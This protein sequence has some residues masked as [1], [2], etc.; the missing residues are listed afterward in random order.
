M[1]RTNRFIGGILLVSGTSI[2]AGMLALP[3]ITS[4]AGF[5]PSL[6]LLAI[7]WLFLFITSL[8]FLD[9]NLATPGEANLSSMV[10]RF[11]GI[12]GKG[13]CWITYLLLLYSL[14]A[15]YIAGS[16]PLFLQAFSW[17]TGWQLPAYLG[18]FPLLFLFGIFVYLGTQAVDWMNRFF[19]LGLIISYIFLIAFLPAHIDLNLLKHFDAPAIWVAI[20][21]MVTSFGFHIIIPTL[22]TYLDHNVKKLRLTLLIGSLIPFVVYALWE[23]L[24]LGVV[25]IEGEHGLVQAWIHGE[26]GA[27]SLSFIL[28]NRWITTAASVFSFFAIITSFLGVSLSLSD[29]LTD[30]LKMK[31]FSL[32]REL[33][34]LLTFIPPLI[35]VLTYQRGFILA[36]QFAGIFV[37]ILL[38]IF[39]ALMAWKLPAYRSFFRR[40]LLLTVIGI[41]LFVIVLDVLE[42]TGV[43]KGL[44][45]HYL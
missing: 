30:G 20:P 29:F 18:P 33:A 44:L 36:L 24:I 40:C 9:A 1:L 41:S 6:A 8:L 27:A 17:L 15:A 23:L 39:P 5:L 12:W 26:T 42:Q 32:G 10:G 38:C 2:G 21:V 14:T 35:F 43:L 28:Q 11:L 19:M 22:T 16:A 34:C 3:V 45:S 37:V 31:R 4:F 13:I 25:P 7:C